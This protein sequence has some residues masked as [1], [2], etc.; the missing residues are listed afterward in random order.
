MNEKIIASF[1]LNN[2]EV[3]LTHNQ[4]SELTK[5]INMKICGHEH[6]NIFD[7]E[8]KTY[9]RAP[10]VTDEMEEKLKDLHHQARMI[11]QV[12]LKVDFLDGGRLLFSTAYEEE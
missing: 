12:P 5:A 8:S 3:K 4:L 7:E 11:W 10:W 6:C 2:V 9:V 1:Q